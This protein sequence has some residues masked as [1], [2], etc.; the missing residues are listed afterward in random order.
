MWLTVYPSGMKLDVT[1]V[2]GS[3]NAIFG[4]SA[5]GGG[6]GDPYRASFRRQI[7]R[8]GFWLGALTAFVTHSIP[9]LVL[10]AP[11]GV[12]G[13]LTSYLWILVTLAPVIVAH[14]IVAALFGLALSQL[15]LMAGSLLTPVLARSM[16][17]RGARIG[18]MAALGALGFVAVA[19]F[20]WLAVGQNPLLA[21]NTGAFAFLAAL[22]P[23]LGGAIL[24]VVIARKITRYLETRS[25]G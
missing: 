1:S 20:A 9:M 24:G 22:A 14:V 4:R 7:T 11:R 21:A 15:L 25:A 3:W 6:L 16:Q 13:G 17:P 19:L 5:R 8:T 23:A 2:S 12:V 10:S 18:L